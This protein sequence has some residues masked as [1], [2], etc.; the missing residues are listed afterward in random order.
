[1]LTN[2]YINKIKIISINAEKAL[3]KIHH[4]F[5]INIP[6]K[7]RIKGDFLNLIE[8]TCKNIQLIS[9]TLAKY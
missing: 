7:L 1:M 2:Y 3:E 9:Y 8:D 4:Q 5:M 6:S